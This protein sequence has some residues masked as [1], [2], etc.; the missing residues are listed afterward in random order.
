[1]MALFNGD[2]KFFL[3]ENVSLIHKACFLNV[4][5]QSYRFS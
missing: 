1:M 2:E 5:S 3:K 4:S